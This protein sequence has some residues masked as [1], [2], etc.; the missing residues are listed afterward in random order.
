MAAWFR[1]VGVNNVHE[2]SWWQELTHPNSSVTL[3]C[4]P[5][6]VTAFNM[7]TSSHPHLFTQVPWLEQCVI[8]VSFY[9]P[10]LL[11]AR[12]SEANSMVDN[13]FSAHAGF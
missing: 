9:L 1:G 8:I 4:T 3:A 10:L 12:H 7:L 5:A 13:D 6:Q 11:C 2:L